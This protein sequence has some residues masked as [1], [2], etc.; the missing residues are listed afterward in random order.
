MT[1]TSYILRGA[2]DTDTH[3]DLGLKVGTLSLSGQSFSVTGSDG[4]NSFFLRPN[5]Y[6]FD[7]TNNAGGSD[8]VYLTGQRSDYTVSIANSVATL[9]RG[10]GD[11]S[12]LVKVSSN[13]SNMTLVFSDGYVRSNALTVAGTETPDEG[14]TSLAPNLPA[15]NTGSVA[16]GTSGGPVDQTNVFGVNGVAFAAYGN[17][18]ID[19]VFVAAGAQV[20]ATRLAAEQDRIYVEGNWADYTKSWAGS[21]ITLTRT[22]VDPLSLTGDTFTEEVKVIGGVGAANDRLYFADGSVDTRAALL[23]LRKHGASHDITN[24]IT[25]W[26]SGNTSFTSSAALEGVDNLSLSGDT[27]QSDQDGIT[28]NGTVSVSGLAEGYKWQYSSDGGSTWQLGSGTTF[29]LDG[30][31]A[32]VEGVTYAAGAVQVRQINPWGVAS[33]AVGN[34]K[35]IVVD[36]NTASTQFSQF[37]SGLVTGQSTSADRG[38]IQYDYD[39]VTGVTIQFWFYLDE[40][41]ST[42]PRMLYEG[43]L[44]RVAL[45]SNTD[46]VIAVRNSSSDYDRTD[47]RVAEGWNFISM[48][49]G[50]PGAGNEVEEAT[51]TLVSDRYPSGSSQISSTGSISA[52]PVIGYLGTADTGIWSAGIVTRDVAVWK[53]V[54]DV[55]TVVA[56]SVTLRDGTEAGLQGYWRLDEGSGATPIN[57]VAEASTSITLAGNAAT[58]A[59]VAGYF[60]G[61]AGGVV[62]ARPHLTGANA[63]ANA[64]VSIFYDDGVGSEQPAGTVRADGAGNWSY[65]FPTSLASGNY[66]VRAEVRDIAGNTASDSITLQVDASIPLPP[67]LAAASDSGNDSD[68][69]TNAL[70]SAMVISGEMPADAISGMEVKIFQNG[71]V[72]ATANEDVTNQNGL[73]LNYGNLTWAYTPQ[74]TLGEGKHAFKVS[75]NNVASSPL[76]VTVDRSATYSSIEIPFT[77]A[78][79]TGNSSEGHD[80]GATVA[81]AGFT[82]TSSVAGWF[83]F[84]D[85]ALSQTLFHSGGDLSVRAVAGGSLQVYAGGSWRSTGF[86]AGEGWHHIAVT[87]SAAGQ[88]FYFDGIKSSMDRSPGATVRTNLGI[89]RR[90]DGNSSGFLGAIRDVQLWSRTLSEDEVRDVYNGATNLHDPDLTGYWKLDPSSGGKNAV[91]GGAD[92]TVQS[93]TE[94]GI[95]EASYR[96]WSEALESSSFVDG[97]FVLTGALANDITTLTVGWDDGDETTTAD[98]SVAASIDSNAGTWTATFT[99]TQM[100]QLA[101]GAALDFHMSATDAADNTHDTTIASAMTV[102]LVN[103]VPESNTLQVIEVQ[104]LGVGVQ[105]GADGVDILSL[106]DLAE[107]G[108]ESTDDVA[109]TDGDLEGTTNAELTY[110]AKLQNGDPLPSWLAMTSAGIL[111]VVAN[112]AVPDFGSLAVTVIATDGAGASATRNITMGT[113]LALTSEVNGESQLDVRSDLVLSALQGDALALTA[114]GNY[115]IRLT[116]Q[117]D[118]TGKTGFGGEASDGSQTISVTVVDGEISA[119]AGGSIRIENGKAI[120]DF[121]HDMDLSSNFTLEVDAGLFVSASSSLSSAAVA[122][123]DIEF[124]TV[125]PADAG[126]TVARVLEAGA[127]VDGETWFDGTAGNYLANQTGN[128]FDLSA[129]SGIVAVGYDTDPTDG[130]DILFPSRT[131]LTGFGQDDY[132]YVDRK[133]GDASN[134]L[135]A[136]EITVNDNGANVPTILTFSGDS[137]TAAILIAFADNPATANLQENT[138]TA[139]AFTQEGLSAGE[140]SFET[141]TGNAAPVIGG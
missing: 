75:V 37:V 110:S 56:D 20:D 32:G 2:A 19:Q 4:D 122:V 65:V 99:E 5:G 24:D 80:G 77:A 3:I 34:D 78:L 6:S 41:T 113:A 69:V 117:P 26:D 101:E 63:E 47:L 48:T 121:E 53:G 109:F 102:E 112:E 96:V 119:S 39:T 136:D 133:V 35:D 103:Q 86:S 91:L 62:S 134:D 46:G 44:L 59:D 27:G 14:E 10:T 1:T 57:L 106:T 49:L 45:A 16:V 73:T 12:E 13:I 42:N 87:D 137:T 141:L 105:G 92:V 15:A 18:G 25:V 118:S 66:T 76:I 127:V 116:Q 54:R 74:G 93:R 43:G 140:Y 70:A 85:L 124:A 111:R 139:T 107:D 31:T 128:S 67:D 22:V 21:H 83:H 100:R 115:E 131:N 98:P 84:D 68:N 81:E 55:G 120:I 23:A 88:D 95:G 50:A 114:N 36:G 58:G 7:F 40:L 123:G 51:I 129:V 126:G 135:S 138:L 17:G 132:I 82:S 97:N 71:E 108:S 125:T 30:Q 90:Y 130:I 33:A 89:G 61:A 8:K 60:P 38:Q 104:K 52:G 94:A 9:S 79:E 64:Q 11:S 29:D 28:S 72:V